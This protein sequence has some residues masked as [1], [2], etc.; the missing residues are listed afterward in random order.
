MF[1]FKPQSKKFNPSWKVKHLIEKSKADQSDFEPKILWDFK[2]P[3][4]LI[5]EGFNVVS[6]DENT[7]SRGIL[8]G[9]N[10]NDFIHGTNENDSIYGQHG[11]DLIYGGKGDDRLYG[12]DSTYRSTDGI[13]TIYGGSGNDVIRAHIGFGENGND[14]LYAPY[15]GGAYLDGGVGDDRLYGRSD[16]DTLV[17]GSGNDYLEG[18]KESDTMTG[19]DGADTFIIGHRDEN[20]HYEHPDGIKT[21]LITD[22]QDV[23]DKIQFE[24]VNSGNIL[25]SDLEFAFNSN[26]T[27]IVSHELGLLAEIQGLNSGVDLEEQIQITRS[28]EINLIAEV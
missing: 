19:R 9:E 16:R 6:H 7:D 24:L 28:H 22:F 27:L 2:N 21:D 3:P 23:G 1:F 17:G 25:F 10:S 26:G 14:R 20:D 11:S 18:K 5:R 15:S 4:K 13:D 8:M 12:D